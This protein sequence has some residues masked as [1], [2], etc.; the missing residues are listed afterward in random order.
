MQMPLAVIKLDDIE[1]RKKKTNLVE[2]PSREESLY[3]VIHY[4]DLAKIERLSV[5]HQFRSQKLANVNVRQAYRQG[6]KWAAHQCPIAH[7]GIW[8]QIKRTL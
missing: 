8:K 5:F 4:E 3:E 2:Y 6:R 1:I 7:P